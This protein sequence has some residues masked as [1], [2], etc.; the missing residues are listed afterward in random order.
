MLSNKEMGHGAP[1]YYEFICPCRQAL[2]Q[3]KEGSFL[4]EG[5]DACRA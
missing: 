3:A 1:A 2:N 5:L 4:W